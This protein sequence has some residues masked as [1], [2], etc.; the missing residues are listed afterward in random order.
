MRGEIT[1]VHKTGYNVNVLGK[2]RDSIKVF[3]IINNAFRSEEKPLVGD[4]VTL[5]QREDQY[6]ITEVEQRKNVIARFDETKSKYQGIA[7]NVDVIFVVTSANREFSINRIKRFLA[8]SGGQPIRKVIVI[9]KRDLTKKI[10]HYTDQ[11]GKEL[12]GV[13]CIAINSL[14]AGDVKKLLNFWEVPGRALLMGSSGVGKSTIINT[15]C[16]TSLK[17]N[18]VGRDKH[19]N[20]GKHTTSSRNMYNTTC[21]RKVIDIPGVKII[22]IEPEVAIQS[23]IFERINTIA[24]ACKFRNCKHLS[25]VDCAVK[26]AVKSGDLRP[27][28]LEGFHKILLT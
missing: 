23:E 2:T 9:T 15:L 14:L 19:F 13:E 7:A 28:E 8:L 6:I 5:E 26:A 3:A 1:S 16:G 11:I 21:G 25:E 22:G 24:Q 20:K 12:D 27:E 18:V 17:T 4:F 10:K